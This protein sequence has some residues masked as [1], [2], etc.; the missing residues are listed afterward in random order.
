MVAFKW[1]LMS[2]L[3]LAFSGCAQQP[4]EQKWAMD[5]IGPKIMQ[6]LQFTD[7]ASSSGKLESSKDFLGK[8]VVLYFGYTHCPDVCPTTM[9]HLARA[10]QLLGPQ[11]KDVQVIFVT[12]DPKRDTPKV[13]DAYVQAFMSSAIGLS[14]TVAQTKTLAGRYHVSYSYGKPDA[15][16]NYVVNHSAAIYVFGPHGNGRLIGTELTPPEGIAHDVHQLLADAH[17]SWWQK[18]V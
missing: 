1:M 17:K 8:V 18:L 11:G 4:H 9:A 7:M 12:V 10:E 15:H 2:A 13:L 14:G 16:G 5:Y 3:V 6:P